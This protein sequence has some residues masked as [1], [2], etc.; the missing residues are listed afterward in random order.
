M[1]KKTKISTFIEK[2]IKNHVRRCY[3]LKQEID[4]DYYISLLRK[5]NATRK[6]GI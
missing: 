1:K 2:S 4:I 5:L 6:M 3:E